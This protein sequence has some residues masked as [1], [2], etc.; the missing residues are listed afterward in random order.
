MLVLGVNRRKS[1]FLERNGRSHRNAR[2]GTWLV[3]WLY[4]GRDHVVVAKLNKTK[5]NEKSKKEKGKKRKI[6]FFAEEISLK[7]VKES[8]DERFECTLP[9]EP[10]RPDGAAKYL[11]LSLLMLPPY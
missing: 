10:S 2:G 5:I 7:M 1:T 3:G 11:L 4:A 8:T 6:F 9:P